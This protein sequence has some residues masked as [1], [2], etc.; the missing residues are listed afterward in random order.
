MPVYIGE[1]ARSTANYLNRTPLG[2]GTGNLLLLAALV[3]LAM[4]TVVHFVGGMKFRWARD[5]R[6]FIYA[7]T[8]TLFLLYLHD[9]RKHH[10][11][12]ELMHELCEAE[13]ASDN[14]PIA[15][16]RPVQLQPLQPT[17][18]YYPGQTQTQPA[19][20][21]GQTQTQPAYY[22]GQTQPPHQQ[23]QPHQPSQQPHQQPPQQLHQQPP[24]QLQQPQEISP[25]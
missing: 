21:P 16:Y 24:Q 25:F 12:R 14:I 4:L 10:P 23:P 2:A 5:T 9:S 18:A 7:Y 11:K 1:C 15:Q 22:P 3:V 20:Y 17:P 6:M 8:V 19:Y 13:P